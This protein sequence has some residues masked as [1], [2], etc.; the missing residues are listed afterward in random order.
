MIHPDT[1]QAGR[2]EP[3]THGQWPGTDRRS[4]PRFPVVEDRI[5]LGWWDDREFQTL[6][7]RLLNIS[8]TG[9]ALLSPELLRP[10]T[11][12]WFS[13]VDPCWCG[14]AQAIVIGQEPV[15]SG[16]N[17]HRIRLKFTNACPDD[18]F[19]AAVSYVIPESQRPAERLVGV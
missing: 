5:W 16:L 15:V 2:S 13:I 1:Q 17:G 10:A 4:A 19:Y 3:T 14:S 12:V 11:D 18:L 6:G 9:A 8:R 7:C